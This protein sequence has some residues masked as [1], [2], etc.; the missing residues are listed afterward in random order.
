MEHIKELAITLD[1]MNADFQ[2]RFKRPQAKHQRFT[3]RF[4]HKRDDYLAYGNKYCNNFF[5]HWK[6]YYLYAGS[7]ENREIVIHYREDKE[8]L[9]TAIHEGFHQFMH[10]QIDNLIKTAAVV[11]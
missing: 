8:H 10:A 2:R 9:L 5:D 6:G 4:F 3:V 1:A 7:P 11:Q